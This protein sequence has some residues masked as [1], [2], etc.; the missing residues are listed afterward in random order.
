MEKYLLINNYT[1]YSYDDDDLTSNAFTVGSF[2]SIEKCYDAIEDELLGQ[3]CENAENMFELDDCEEAIIK[4]EKKEYVDNYCSGYN[5]FGITEEDLTYEGANR[6]M[7]EHWYNGGN[8]RVENQF[9]VI[10][11]K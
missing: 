8:Y 4:E 3:A 11:V 9:L 6:Y 5:S 1:N 10:R 7:A 2:E